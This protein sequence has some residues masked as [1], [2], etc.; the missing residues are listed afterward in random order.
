MLG[1][2]YA[3]Q[4]WRCYLEGASFKVNSDHLNHTW[5]NKKKDL[6]RRQAK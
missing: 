4:I 6:S 2:Y 5:F 1:I 3:L